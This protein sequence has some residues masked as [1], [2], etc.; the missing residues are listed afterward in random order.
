MRV[1][2]RGFQAAVSTEGPA[3]W[4]RSEQLSTKSGRQ[5][6]SYK[7]ISQ[8]ILWKGAIHVP[9]ISH[10]H[11]LW[12]AFPA[13]HLNIMLNS[14]RASSVTPVVFLKRKKQSSSTVPKLQ[15]SAGVHLPQASVCIRR[16]GQVSKQYI[17]TAQQINQFPW[18]VI[19][20][21]SQQELFPKLLTSSLWR[22]P[23]G[24]GDL[25]AHYTH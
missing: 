23:G 22:E 6:R 15:N 21:N 5:Q 12:H 1:P 20:A 3:I 11:F 4:Q 8:R 24:G 13:T 16:W 25:Q 9:E 19:T 14:L 17:T 7:Q 18:D 10:K 2:R